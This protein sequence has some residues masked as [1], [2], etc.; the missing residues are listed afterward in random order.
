MSSTEDEKKSESSTKPPVVEKKQEPEKQEEIKVKMSYSGRMDNFVVG[1]S[2]TEYEMRLTQFFKVNKTEEDLKVASLITFIG[3]DA[4]SILRKMC[5]PDDP[6]TKTYAA[7]VKTLKEYFDPTIN[8]IS[9]SYKF[10]Q[11]EQGDSSITKYIMKLRAAADNCNFGA[12]LKR[13]LRDKFVSGLRDKHMRSK[14]LKE[15]DLTFQSAGEMALIWESAEKASEKMM[16]K[17]ENRI[18]RLNQKSKASKQKEP[19]H[20]KSKSSQKDCFRCGKNHSPDTCPA[21]EWECFTCKKK[22]HISPKCYAKTHKSK[23]KLVDEL[24][25]ASNGLDILEE[26][27]EIHRVA[28]TSQ[29]VMVPVKVGDVTLHMEIDSGACVSIISEADYSS[30]FSNYPLF[31]SNKNFLSVV[32]EKVECV[33]KITVPVSRLNDSKILKLDL[34]VI[35]STVTV[36]ALLGRTWLDELFPMWRQTFGFSSAGVK[37]IAENSLGCNSTIVSE[38]QEKFP[39]IFR[40]KSVEFID[41]FEAEIV[42][43][44]NSPTLFHKAYPVPYRL[45]DKVECEL[46]RMCES[47]I[48]IPVKDSKYA[49]P[50]VIV[51]K[52][53][54]SLRICIDC[55]VTINPY[56]QDDH[57]PL[58]RSDDIFA[59]MS[60]WNWMFKLDLEGAYLQLKLSDVSREYVTINTVIGLL[61]YVAMP[62]GV[63]NGPS[64]FQRLMD[65]IFRGLK[66]VKSFLDDVIG[67]G[68]TFEECKEVLFQVLSR[69]NEFNV[70]IKI[71]KCKFMVREVKF[72]GHI[73]GSTGIRPNPDKVS[74]IQ[75]APAPSNKSELMSYLGLLNYY[76]NFIPNLASELRCLY[77]L[78]GNPSSF[79]WS[80]VQNDC[81]ER[82]K[83]LLLKYNVL[84]RYDPE[85]EIV[86][87]CD[88]SPYG[89]GAIMAHKVKS[90]ER[91]VTFI[92][93]TLSPAEK[94]YAQIHREALSVV[95]AVQKLYK[96]LYG[97]KFEIIT[98]NQALCE[99]FNP[100][101]STSHLASSRLQKWATYLS[102][103]DYSIKYRPGKDNAAD[104]LSRLPVQGNTNVEYIRQISDSCEEFVSKSLVKSHILGDEILMKVVSFVRDGWSKNIEDVYVPYSHKKKELS[105][106]DGLLYYRD[107]LVI[108]KT[109]RNNV[110]RMLHKNH[111]G[112]VRMKMVGRSSI[113][114]H[115]FDKGIEEF[116]K[117]CHVCQITRNVPKE[118]VTSSWPAATYPFHRVHLDLFQLLN[119]HFLILVDAFSKYIDVKVMSSTNA[120]AVCKY[121]RRFCRDYGF[122][123]EVVSDNGPPF[124]SKEFIEFLEKRG[125]KVTKTPIY[126]P[127]SN[128][129]AE[130]GVGTIKTIMK[131]QLLDPELKSLDIDARLDHILSNYNHYPSTV[132]NR[133]PMSVILSFAPRTKFSLLKK[134]VVSSVHRI[135]KT[136]NCTFEVGQMVKYKLHFKDIVKW[137]VVKILKKISPL[138]YLIDLDGTVKFVHQNQLQ[139]YFKEQPF[140][141]QLPNPHISESVLNE[142]P[143]EVPKKVVQNTF[144]KPKVVKKEIAKEHSRSATEGGRTER[145]RAIKV[146]VDYK[147]QL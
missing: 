66:N 20:S 31:Y 79:N 40:T 144:R 74:A 78:L 82:S 53:D 91:P 89:V 81:F 71:E 13:A 9:E 65:Q 110:I 52:S 64:E 88:G 44:E 62:P 8:E 98:D 99:I 76:R 103:F 41:R 85:K 56:I 109:L 17:P 29:S 130:R 108:P 106:D 143:K 3:A 113:W 117:S 147:S 23:V 61:Q 60:D 116:V 50:I 84:E 4:F 134:N 36:R 107:R 126:H 1:T 6:S 137:V 27:C 104:A 70:K 140:T 77:D 24:S 135:E 59:S 132:T 96:F 122:F 21:R 93:S 115:N 10:Y 68:K 18:G 48:L 54:G 87:I 7:L 14:L 63:K 35:N 30:K 57:Y 118:V 100:K 22:G 45:R 49:S 124:N 58:S 26:E 83:N 75:N 102:I 125:T 16:A 111:E 11:I 146:K 67:G 55:K 114:W 46:K 32:G 69:L 131:K 42:L 94:N 37:V 86:L 34:F 51:P 129:Q 5:A 33:G 138:T 15:K 97:K 112:I 127:A 47:G 139:P 90:E 72:L 39:R 43:K 145:P 136:E 105:L 73:I 2:F 142:K 141:L 25:S 80:K 92:S 19:S 133:S 123:G 95:F 28:S 120:S 12:F 101:K 119:K 121:L 38:I 128:G